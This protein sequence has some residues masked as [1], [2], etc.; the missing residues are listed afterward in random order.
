M[1]GRR[2][3]RGRSCPRVRAGGVHVRTSWRRAAGV[4]GERED[5]GEDSRGK[6]RQ[7]ASSD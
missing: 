5:T 2:Q 7:E 4:R 3:G 6:C 1:E